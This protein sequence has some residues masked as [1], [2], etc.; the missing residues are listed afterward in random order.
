MYCILNKR[1]CTYQVD[2]KTW[3]VGCE[4]ERAQN[5]SDCTTHWMSTD[6]SACD[7]CNKS[8][9]SSNWSCKFLEQNDDSIKED[10]KKH[11]RDLFSKQLYRERTLYYDF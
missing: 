3:I 10:K 2:C 4:K 9:G 8:K 11:K 1:E 6:K 7:S 5:C